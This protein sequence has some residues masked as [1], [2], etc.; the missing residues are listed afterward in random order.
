MENNHR[1]TGLPKEAPRKKTQNR[2]AHYSYLALFHVGL[3]HRF[4][5]TSSPRNLQ[6]IFNLSY[7]QASL[8]P[9][10]LLF[11]LLYFFHSRSEAY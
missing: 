4:G 9:I 5:T 10:R 7:K 2:S 3:L 8:V 11:R 6:S 1:T